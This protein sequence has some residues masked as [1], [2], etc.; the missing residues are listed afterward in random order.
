MP[1]HLL[2]TTAI[3]TATT[4]AACS[5][6]RAATSSTPHK[7]FIDPDYQDFQAPG[8][9]PKRIRKFCEM[10]NQPQP[11]GQ[12]E[13]IRCALESLAFKCRMV[14]DALED[15]SQEK[16]E[17]IHMLGG[18]IKDKM[19]CGFVANATKRR[20]IAGPVEAT[21]TGNA[22]VQLMA[23]GKVADLKEARTAVKNSFPIQV[24]EPENG[25]EWDKAYEEFKKYAK[26]S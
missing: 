4:T 19:F 13:I 11:E 12:G 18:G 23:L 6:S 5:P 22:L 17:V 20:V 24:Y 26:L 9:M 2:L 14:V 1:P 8:N 3:S 21:G 10:T 25:E 16:I 7:A 15:I